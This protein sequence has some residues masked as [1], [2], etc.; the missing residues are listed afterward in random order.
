MNGS[1]SRIAGMVD[2]ASASIVCLVEDL[3]EIIGGDETPLSVGNIRAV[4]AEEEEDL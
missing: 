3:D 2:I 4:H 1:I